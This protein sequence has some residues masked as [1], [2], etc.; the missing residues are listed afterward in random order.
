MNK[1]LKTVRT[2]FEP[3]TSLLTATYSRPTELTNH[4]Y[5]HKKSSKNW[6]KKV[7]YTFQKKY[8]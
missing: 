2:G 1:I 8:N 4:K 5:A 7:P 3:V 6:N